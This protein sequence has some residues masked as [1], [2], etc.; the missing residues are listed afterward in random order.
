VDHRG[1]NASA[2]AGK[3]KGWGKE[4]RLPVPFQAFLLRGNPLLITSGKGEEVGEK[5]PGRGVNGAGGIRDPGLRQEG[6]TFNRNVP[7]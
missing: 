4:N 2:I 7:A 3:G 6:D 1:R 5:G